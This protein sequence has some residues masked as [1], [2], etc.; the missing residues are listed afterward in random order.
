MRKIIILIFTISLLTLGP[1]FF[2]FAE[3]KTKAV[4]IDI[5]KKVNRSLPQHLPKVI[6]KHSPHQLPK[7]S[8]E[9]NYE[10]VYRA[11]ETRC[12]IYFG[13]NN[14]ITVRVTEPGYIEL[15]GLD[16][17]GFSQTLGFE[18]AFLPERKDHKPIQLVP[19]GIIQKKCI[20]I[21]DKLPSPYN[22]KFK[23]LYKKDIR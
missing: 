9:V 19:R 16:D 21:M 11:P 3:N 10:K 7:Q 18:M 17:K 13:T 12:E 8:I 23:K 5:T 14:E 22:E 2:S 20:P 15:L 4:W 1:V 6:P